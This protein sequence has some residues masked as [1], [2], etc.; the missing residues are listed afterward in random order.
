MRYGEPVQVAR[1]VRDGSDQEITPVGTINNTVFGRIR[2]ASLDHEERGRRSTVERNWFCPTGSNVQQ[3][4]RITRTNGDTYS[5]ISDAHGDANHP[6]TGHQFGY[7]KYRL[8]R[9]I[10]PRG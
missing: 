1:P 5:V 6:I 7:V 9:V 8:R 10:A 2:S 4:D 3:G